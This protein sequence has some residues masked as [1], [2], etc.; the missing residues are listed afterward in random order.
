[1]AEQFDD[2]TAED[3]KKLILVRSGK[4]KKELKHKKRTR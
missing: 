2:K 3:M 1:M 4:K